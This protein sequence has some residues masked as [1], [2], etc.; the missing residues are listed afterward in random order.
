MEEEAVLDSMSWRGAGGDLGAA[1]VRRWTQRRE[2]PPQLRNELSSYIGGVRPMAGTDAFAKFRADLTASS[3]PGDK[4]DQMLVAGYVLSK[5]H[6]QARALVGWERP[7]SDDI[8]KPMDWLLEW[9][10]ALRFPEVAGRRTGSAGADGPARLG[11]GAVRPRRSADPL[12]AEEHLHE[13]RGEMEAQEEEEDGDAVPLGEATEAV[14]SQ[15]REARA[16]IIALPQMLSE[17]VVGQDAAV[18]LVADVMQMC[19]VGLREPRGPLGTFLFVGPTGVGKTE[20]A[21]ALAVSVF[22][23][24]QHMFRVDMSAFKAKGDVAT[25]IGAPR[26]YTDSSQGGTL[27]GFLQRLNKRGRGGAVVLLDEVE[28]AHEEVVD[29]FLPAFDEGYLVDG[30]G[31]RHGCKQVLFV[32]TS[33]LGSGALRDRLLKRRPLSSAGVEERISAEEVER[34]V[35]PHVRQHL[36]P[37]LLGRLDGVA[38]FTPLGA[39]E[40]RT[41]VALQLQQLRAR[42][43]QATQGACSLCWEDSVPTHVL[44]KALQPEHGARSV[45]RELHTLVVAPLA[46]LLLAVPQLKEL[47]RSCCLQ[48]GA[49]S[50]KLTMQIRSA[51]RL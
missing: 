15:T 3:F 5:L 38:Y 26:G 13:R 11:A 6:Q 7:V 33:N 35:L 41:I 48:V 47:P 51:S 32:M 40:I 49:E 20:L 18:A 8:L 44:D 50:G 10:P 30:R 21:K 24:E 4:D 14:W 1:Q 17:L 16:R 2:R 22:G 31:A 42:L 46:K 9:F 36:R 19:Y 23:S 45:K 43:L 37:E 39:E 12:L 29:L 27:T 28:K 25:L 34:I